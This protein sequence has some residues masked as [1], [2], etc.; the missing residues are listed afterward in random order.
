MLHRAKI[1][2]KKKN[3]INEFIERWLTL[4]FEKDDIK[5]IITT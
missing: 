5:N 1:R 2:L 3:L 4:V